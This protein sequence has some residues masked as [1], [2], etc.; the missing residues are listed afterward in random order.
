MF[1]WRDACKPA[2]LR[3]YSSGVQVSSCSLLIC[4]LKYGINRKP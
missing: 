1:E 3:R 4:I 2:S